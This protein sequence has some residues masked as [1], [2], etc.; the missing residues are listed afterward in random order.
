MKV[1]GLPFTSKDWYEKN[2]KNVKREKAVITDNTIEE[3]EDLVVA[4]AVED[5][6]LGTEH[7]ELAML[8]QVLAPI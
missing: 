8:I 7:L 4:G 2:K 5:T 1:L 3:E 6:L